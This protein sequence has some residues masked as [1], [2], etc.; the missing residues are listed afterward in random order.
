MHKEHRELLAEQ[1]KT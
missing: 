1:T